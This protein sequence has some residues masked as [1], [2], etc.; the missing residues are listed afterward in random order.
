MREI[1][2]IIHDIRSAHNVGSLLRTAE[3]LGVRHVY[4]SGY[5]P[6]PAGEHDERLPH[7]AAK[8]TKQIEKTSLGAEKMIPWSHE[9]D[10]TSLMS[11][12]KDEGFVVIALEQDSRST[13]LPNFVPPEKMALLIGREVEG[14]DSALLAVCDTV[15][16]IPQFGRKESLNV[17]Q[18]TAIALYHCSLNDLDT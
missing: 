11:R 3:C 15:V 2:L 4:L 6:Y 9:T 7:I 10:V 14:I 17:A 16:E 8:L 12:L 1:V 13:P 5:T 18:A